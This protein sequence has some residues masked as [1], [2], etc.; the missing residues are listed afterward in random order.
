MLVSARES[1][2]QGRNREN[3][4][5][6]WRGF[7]GYKR[8]RGPEIDEFGFFIGLPGQWVVLPDCEMKNRA[9]L[10][11]QRHFRANGLRNAFK[12]LY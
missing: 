11:I 10:Q 8:L 1:R 6:I 7:D 9:P 2:S 5:F 3:L 12:R 4:F